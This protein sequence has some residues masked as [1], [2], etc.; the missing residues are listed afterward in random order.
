MPGMDRDLLHR[1]AV[2]EDIAFATH[3]IGTHDGAGVDTEF[4]AAVVQ[5][6]LDVSAIA[7]AG[8]IDAIRIEDATAGGG[9]WATVAGADVVRDING[10]EVTLP[11]T[12]T[13]KY[14]IKSDQQHR[15]HVRL[16]PSNPARGQPCPRVASL[17]GDD[18]DHQDGHRA[19]HA[20]RTRR[21]LDSQ[22]TAEDR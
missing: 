5:C 3:A 20:S 12:A 15:R 13:G 8:Q 4:K 6:Q 9:P 14:F 21:H 18:G 7:G 22:A 1:V 16:V 19:R 17:R 10:D 11:I 2:D